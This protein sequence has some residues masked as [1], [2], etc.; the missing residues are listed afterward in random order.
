MDLTGRNYEL[1]ASCDLSFTEPFSSYEQTWRIL[2]AYEQALAQ[3]QMSLTNNTIRTWLYVSDIDNQ[4]QGMA[5]ARREFF[6]NCGMTK[7]THFIAST[8]IAG[9]TARPRT[10]VSMDALSISNI[11]P[12]QVTQL[13]APTHLN[14]THEYGVTFERGTKVAFG[15]RTHYYI[16]GTASIDKYGEVI[17]VNDIEKQTYRTIENINSLLLP[18]GRS[19]NDMA[20][21]LVYLR[22]PTHFTY[23][24][25]VLETV[26]DRRIPRLY[27]KARVCRPAWLVEI[28]A[29]GVKDASTSFP[30]FI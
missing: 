9:Q 2:E 14:P 26:V 22:D 6:E 15:D 20:Y 11:V 25:D 5:D 12:E 19:I 28:E 10:I 8:G 30:E 13:S 3:R 1:Y 18:E 27:L 24:R 7:D 4:Y 23:V 21:L 17:H 16:S 29:F